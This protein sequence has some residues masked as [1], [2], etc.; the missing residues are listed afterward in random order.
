MIAN[1]TT[2]WFLVATLQC[3]WF[4]VANP[5]MWLVLS[6]KPYNLI[7]YWWQTL[8]SDWLLV[9]NPTI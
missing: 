9:A 2:N 8:Q 7:G 5:T 6:G 1:P 4:F 3:D